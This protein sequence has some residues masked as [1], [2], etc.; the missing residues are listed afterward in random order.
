[1]PLTNLVKLVL[2][3]NKLEH[4]DPDLFSNLKNLE[5]LWISDNQIK[6]LSSRNFANNKKL[7]ELRFG[8]NKI[9]KIERDTFKHLNLLE[10][11]DLSQNSCVDKSYGSSSFDSESEKSLIKIDNQHLETC[12]R[13]YECLDKF[14]VETY[15][16]QMIN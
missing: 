14:R 8:N 7:R 16:W 15:S 2:S 5:L 9:Y 12:F 10:H 4:L 1:M 13:I 11:L 3:N 6:T